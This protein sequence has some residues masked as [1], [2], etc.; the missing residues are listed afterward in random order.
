MKITI[1]AIGQKM[2]AW[3][4][5]G[6]KEYASRFRGNVSLSL[7]EI[8]APRRTA[9]SVIERIK[10]DE[11][12]RLLAA[13]PGASVIVALDEHGKSINTKELA[14]KLNGWIE[15]SQDIAILIG[16]PDGLANECLQQAQQ[17]WSLSALTF[18]H[19]LVRVI[20][21]EQLYRAWSLTQN[22][23]YHRE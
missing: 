12:Q 3:V 18:P 11:A 1:V 14:T 8:A 15:Q 5:Q 6:Y 20:L 9:N 13:V 2:P 4:E 19:P 10:Q 16:G 21:A 22:H 7:K 23:P 17:R